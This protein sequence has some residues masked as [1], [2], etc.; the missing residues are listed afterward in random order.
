MDGLGMPD[1]ML[2][3]G[4]QQSVGM[5]TTK[6][7]C[8]HRTSVLLAK[9]L[10]LG[11]LPACL[12]AHAFVWSCLVLMHHHDIKTRALSVGAGESEALLTKKTE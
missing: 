4:L 1:A 10:G 8:I 9:A 12:H 11:R 2:I 6:Y 7:M 3:A 5:D